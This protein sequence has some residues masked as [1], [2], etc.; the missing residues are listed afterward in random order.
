[1]PDWLQ[2]RFV[3][4]ECRKM[5][6]LFQLSASAHADSSL[7]LAFR[8]VQSSHFL[9]L[10]SS[11]LKSQKQ[12]K[13]PPPTLLLGRKIRMLVLTFFHRKFFKTSSNSCQCQ[14]SSTPDQ[15]ARLS[16]A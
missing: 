1:M 2:K 13:L 3:K 12:K 9:L 16:E 10:V 4:M 6:T 11:S 7:T 8:N 15:A 5:R 14:T